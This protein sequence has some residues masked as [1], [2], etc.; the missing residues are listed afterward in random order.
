MGAH[1]NQCPFCREMIPQVSV[2]RPKGKGGGPQIRRGLLY[3]L[4]AAVIYYSAGGY[5][6]QPRIPVQ[7][8][9]LVNNYLLPVL[10]LGGLGLC[11]YGLILHARP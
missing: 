7:I 9:P 10:F 11:V 3:M 4:L 5:G 2:S 6:A 8:V 1:L